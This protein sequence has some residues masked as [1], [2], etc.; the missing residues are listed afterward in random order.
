MP[1]GQGAG[2]RMAMAARI[3]GRSN[4]DNGERK[5]VDGAAEERRELGV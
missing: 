4:V 5:L 1:G 3:G 2:T